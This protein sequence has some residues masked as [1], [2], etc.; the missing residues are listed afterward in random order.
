MLDKIRVICAEERTLPVIAT[1]LRYTVCL[2]NDDARYE[3]S[4]VVQS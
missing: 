1:H 4:T 3:V 2:V